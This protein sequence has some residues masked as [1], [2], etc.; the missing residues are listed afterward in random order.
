MDD[1][2]EDDGVWL[3]LVELAE[4]FLEPSVRMKATVN[5]SRT[6]EKIVHE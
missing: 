5:K 2:N 3:S 6:F 1:F 4:P